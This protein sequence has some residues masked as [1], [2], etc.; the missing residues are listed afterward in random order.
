MY[1]SLRQVLV[2]TRLQLVHTLYPDRLASGFLIVWLGFCRCQ[3]PEKPVSPVIQRP[4]DSAVGGWV[5]G[6]GSQRCAENGRV[7][8]QARVRE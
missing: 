8:A 1:W 4:V 6:S 2:D 3:V 5:R 7:R